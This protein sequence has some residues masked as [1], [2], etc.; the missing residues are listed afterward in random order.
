MRKTVFFVLLLFIL[1][2]C[3]EREIYTE[4]T[5]T[6]IISHPPITLQIEDPNSILKSDFKTDSASPIKMTIY[7][8][9][10]KCTNAQSKS[11]GSDFDGYIR[12]TLTDN[13]RTLARAQMDYK[14]EATPKEVAQVYDHLMERLQWADTLKKN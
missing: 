3:L 12:I 1:I 14:G 7:I 13:N 4:I 10:T 5:D 8:H 2:G 9:C 11:F 6:S